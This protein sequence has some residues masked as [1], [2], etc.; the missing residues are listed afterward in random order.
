MS[1]QKLEGKNV[2]VDE[3]QGAGTIINVPNSNR[4][5]TPTGT[6]ACCCYLTDPAGSPPDGLGLFFISC[7]DGVTEEA[8]A[9]SCHDDT[10]TAS[11]TFHSGE[12]CNSGGDRGCAMDEYGFS[13][14][15]W[16]NCPCL[17]AC[18]TPDG[19][20]FP[21]TELACFN[22]VGGTWSFS[23]C[24]DPQNF[25]CDDTP[26]TCCFDQCTFSSY[27][28]TE[29]RALGGIFVAANNP[30]PVPCCGSDQFCC[31]EGDTASRCCFSDTDRCC[32]DGADP[33]NYYCCLVEQECCEGTC[34]N[35]DETCC[36]DYCCSPPQVC[37]E[38]GCCDP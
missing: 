1:L 6:G 20:C 8:C 32:T 9:A 34:C 26:G 28:C 37:C 31:G 3:R 30:Q 16:A 24:P 10:Y 2:S 36:G 25:P 7:S 5:S 11:Y 18:T 17:G 38:T 22:Q 27:S 15:A 4:R 29:C 21:V 19:T 33:N 13:P 12:S 35:P 14:G 23:A